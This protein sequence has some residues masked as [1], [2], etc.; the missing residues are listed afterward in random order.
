MAWF[1]RK[2]EERELTLEELLLQ[3]NVDAD[4]VTTTAALNIPSV[5]G[6]IEL[7][8]KTVAMLPIQLFKADGDKVVEIKNDIRTKL[9]N[10]DTKDTM[11]GF[12]FKKALIKDYLL[13]GNGYA[14][15]N[16]VRNQVKSLHFI[17][18]KY[19]SITMG[20]DPIFKSYDIWINGKSYRDFEFIKLTRNTKDGIIGTGIVQENPQLLAVAYNTMIYENLLVKTGGNKK[21]FLKAQSKLSES[22]ITALKAAWNNLYKNNTENVVVLNNGLEFQ[23]ASNTSVE[24]QLNENKK[25]NSTEICKLFNIPASILDGKFTDEEYFNFIKTSIL[26][27][28]KAL[29]TALNKDLLLESEKG[30]F[31]FVVNTKEL[32]KGDMSKRYNAYT[33]ACKAGWLSKNEIRYIED[34]EKIDGL[35][36]VTMSLGD[37]VYDINSKKYFTPNTNSLL[38]SDMS[39]TEEDMSKGGEKDEKLNAD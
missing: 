28:L 10:D 14:Y 12:Q 2:K 19:L 27:I 31:Y 25:T 29:E 1:T 21:G 15:I 11:D 22:A 13:E 8:S 5:S 37:V 39:A 30:S 23:E 4:T 16:K 35:D 33:E 34:L 32:L 17:D 38:S 24:M 20:I 26:P 9:L 3:A 36:V 6:C 18:S 7:I